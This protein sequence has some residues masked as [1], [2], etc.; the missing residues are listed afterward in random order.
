MLS[1]LGEADCEIDVDDWTLLQPEEGPSESRELNAEA[2]EHEMSKLKPAPKTVK[3]KQLKVECTPLPDAGPSTSSGTTRTRTLGTVTVLSDSS[4]KKKQI[5]P[6]TYCTAT[7]E[8]VAGLRYHLLHTHNVTLA[9]PC[10][11]CGQEFNNNRDLRSH[12]RSHTDTDAVI[13]CAFCKK[14]CSL[15]KHDVTR[16]ESTCAEN[17]VKKWKCLKCPNQ[18]LFDNDEALFS[19]LRSKHKMTGKFG[20]VYCKTLFKTRKDLDSHKCPV[21]RR[22]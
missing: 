7:Y 13:H 16:H 14:Y 20:C 6:C 8:T 19:H 3:L 1:D 21:K 10:E 22:P 4:G 2:L 18:K 15:H 11:H 5:H 12:M 9:F 17:P